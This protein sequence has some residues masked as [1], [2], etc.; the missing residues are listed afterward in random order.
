MNR[1]TVSV[2]D[3]SSSVLAGKR[4]VI[5]RA[6]S[7]SAALIETLRERGAETISVPLIRIAPPDFAP[8][9]SALRDLSNF[10][11][12]IFT[13][14]NAVTA[15]SDRLIALSNPQTPSR[16]AL[17]IAAVGKS[18]ATAAQAAGFIVDHTGNGTASDLVHDL[19]ND[20]RAKRIFLPRSDRASAELVAQL[21][22]L[23]A[24]ITEVVAY[25]TIPLDSIDKS[26]R[27]LIFQADAILFFSPSAVN[28]FLDLTKSGVLS[29]LRTGTAIGAIGPVT[30]AALRQAGL[31]CDFE[32]PEPGVS[33]IVA[34]LVVHFEK[35]KAP[36][37]FGANS[38]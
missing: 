10:D 30:R 23:G 24:Y 21:L 8:L 26:S 18:T 35:A 15:V 25:R 34:A 27:E 20:L 28:A 12:L 36:S 2:A 13:S 37:V 17:R 32:A 7:Q 3:H 19:A 16:D 9:D 5:T 31:R 1:F 14:Q 6:E 11:W 22:A 4:V 38:Q 29:F 33:E